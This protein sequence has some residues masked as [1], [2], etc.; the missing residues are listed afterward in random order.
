M[1][2]KN[3]KAYKREIRLLVYSELLCDVPVNNCGYLL[4]C[5]AKVFCGKSLKNVPCPATCAQMAYELGTLTTLQ[6]MEYMLSS[7]ENEIPITANR[8]ECPVLDVRSLP[9]GK[10]ADYVLH[11]VNA[12]TDAAEVFSKFTGEPFQELMAKLE[13]AVS[14]TLTDRAAVNAC[15]TRQLCEELD[16]QLVMVNCN[17]HPLD[18]VAR[19]S[20]LNQVKLDTNHAIKGKCFGSEGSAA[21][22]INAISVLR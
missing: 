7:N 15:V 21:N 20:K 10:T 8:N 12:L 16:S 9:G 2:S 18:S 4:N 11:I 1:I 22:L 13:T 19:Q 6:V 17:I 5:F 3:G 14:S